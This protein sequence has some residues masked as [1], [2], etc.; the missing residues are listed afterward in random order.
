MLPLK[1]KDQEELV[2]EE[3]QD[4]VDELAN[5]Y[6]EARDI[7]TELVLEVRLA[8]LDGPIWVGPGGQEEAVVKV[9]DIRSK[10]IRAENFLSEH[11]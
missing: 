4:G 7:L 10:L 9:E 5:S 11:K 8:T 6:V 2:T 1:H 3:V